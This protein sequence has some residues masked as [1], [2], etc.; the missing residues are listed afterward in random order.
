[1]VARG[2]TSVL[3]QIPLYCGTQTQGTSAHKKRHAG[4]GYV[5][6]CCVGDYC[7]NGTFPAL[8]QVD[9][10]GINKQCIPV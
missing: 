4:A 6:V 5:I 9:Y 3:Q 10:S 8:P 2:C 7:N 1:M